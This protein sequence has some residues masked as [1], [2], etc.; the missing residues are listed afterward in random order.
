MHS[1]A[2][3]VAE[4]GHG[5]VLNEVSIRHDP[6]A[7]SIR[8]LKGRLWI[9]D[10]LHIPHV[11]DMFQLRRAV[12]YLLPN[13]PSWQIRSSSRRKQARPKMSAPQLVLA[14]VTFFQ[15]R[16][17]CSISSNRRTLFRPG[18]DGPRYFYGLKGF[19]ESARQRVAT[20]RLSS[21]PFAR[22]C[23]LPNEFG[24]QPIATAR[25]S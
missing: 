20:R 4:G 12:K 15:L 5:V 11:H 7:A 14:T 23:A 13:G 8:Q 9:Q 16:A 19:T 10:D 2:G 22:H 6:A 24:L 3:N 18:S 25:V 1:P 21:R 17:I